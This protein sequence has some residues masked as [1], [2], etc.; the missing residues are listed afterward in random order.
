MCVKQ[1]HWG[2]LRLAGKK[3][4]VLS[5]TGDRSF[6]TGLS[7]RWR[8]GWSGEERAGTKGEIWRLIIQIFV[9]AAP[10]VKRL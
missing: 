6:P 4:G 10:E 2:L 1:E 9:R 7:V 3:V 8:T 5:E